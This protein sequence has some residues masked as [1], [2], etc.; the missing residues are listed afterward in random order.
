MRILPDGRAAA[1]ADLFCAGGKSGLHG[2]MVADNVRPAQ[3]EGKCHREETALV[4]TRVRVKGCGKSAPR[5]PRGKR[6]GKPH[7]EQDR[8]GG[9]H[10]L[11][12]PAPR[13]CRVRR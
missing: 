3:A 5:E 12:R 7:L 1:G 11:L 9:V 10:G 6:Q 2:E 4:S 13:V 8:I